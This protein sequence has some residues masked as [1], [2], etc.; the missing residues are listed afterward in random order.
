MKAKMNVD[1]NDEN[2]FAQFVHELNKVNEQLLDTPD[3]RA[4]MLQKAKT[5]TMKLE[6]HPEIFDERITGFIKHLEEDIAGLGKETEAEYIARKASGLYAETP[7]F[8]N[9]VR[10]NFDDVNVRNVL[11]GHLETV[12]GFSVESAAGYS[13]K[14]LVHADNEQAEMAVRLI[15]RICDY[16]EDERLC[17][18]DDNSF[19]TWEDIMQSMVQTV[20]YAPVGD[21]SGGRS[22]YSIFQLQAVKNIDAEN[23][24]TSIRLFDSN[25]QFA[26]I[27]IDDKN[28]K[29]DVTFLN[30]NVLD[31]KRIAEVAGTLSYYLKVDDKHTEVIDVLSCYLK[32]PQYHTEFH[33]PDNHISIEVTAFTPTDDKDFAI[34]EMDERS[35]AECLDRVLTT[36]ASKN[37]NFM[38]YDGKEF[39]EDYSDSV[40]T[41]VNISTEQLYVG[42]ED[43]GKRYEQEVLLTPDERSLVTA[44]LGEYEA[45]KGK[46]YIE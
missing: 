9:N 24:D 23:G 3:G 26:E 40:E 44:R 11:V 27:R 13:G 31:D 20:M 12:A 32:E 10:D 6:N 1:P 37:F 17:D 21:D 35:L 14:T 5:F 4:D 33:Y 38:F 22:F 19:I 29:A 41:F 18:Y 46:E 15:S 8:W 30:H 28:K 25:S 43:N 45:G 34:A 42:F 16:E 39:M 36:L 2:S 7:D